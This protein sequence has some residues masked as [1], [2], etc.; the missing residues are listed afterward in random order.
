MFRN[1][2][3][4]FLAAGSMLHAF[5]N[6]R[7]DDITARDRPTLYDKNV[8]RSFDQRHHY[9]HSDSYFYN[10]PYRP[11]SYPQY[12]YPQGSYDN[13]YQQPYSNQQYYYY[14]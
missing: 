7:E 4:F 6:Q 9:Y 3:L 5:P 14:Q 10:Y 13:Y 12:S 2:V 8:E 11:Y 1:L